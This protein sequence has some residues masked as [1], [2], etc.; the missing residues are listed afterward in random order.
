MFAEKFY[1][2]KFTKEFSMMFKKHV[3]KVVLYDEAPT[4]SQ[5]SNMILTCRYHVGNGNNF[6]RQIN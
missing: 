5:T 3:E 6:M 2:I 4:Q 1:N